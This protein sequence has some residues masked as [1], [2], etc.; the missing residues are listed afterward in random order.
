[1]ISGVLLITLLLANMLAPSALA[2]YDDDAQA[3][4]T[5]ME[6][7]DA[8]YMFIPETLEITEETFANNISI[9]D[10]VVPL[11]SGSFL[12]RI[13]SALNKILGGGSSQTTPAPT[14]APTPAP[15]AAPT[16][17]PTAAPT[18]APTAAPTPVPTAAATPVPTATA[19]PTPASPTPTLAPTP[20][21]TVAP[22]PEPDT[23]AANVAELR[24]RSDVVVGDII[25][26][27]GY[28]E[29]EDGGG[30]D[31]EIVAQTRDADNG[32]TIIQL[33]AGFTAK[34]IIANEMNVLQF[35]AVNDG[36]TDSQYAIQAAFTSGASVLNFPKD[37]HL[38]VRGDLFPGSNQTILGNNCT[39]YTDNDYVGTREFFITIRDAQ[40][41]VI[42]GL[43]I[44]S[45]QTMDLVHRKHIALARASNITIANCV[46]TGPEAVYKEDGS[47]AIFAFTNI[48]LYTAWNNVEIY[49]CTLKLSHDGT[50][51][52]TI[53]ARDLLGGVSS[54]LKFH[55][56][57]IEKVCHDELIAVGGT[58]ATVSNVQIYEN[59]MIA[60]DGKLTSSDVAISLGTQGTVFVD[61]VR[62]EN[63]ILDVEVGSMLFYLNPLGNNMSIT[64]NTFNLSKGRGYETS[65]SA[66]YA[67]S[68][69]M[70]ANPK[71]IE[72][73]NNII[74]I[75]N[76]GSPNGTINSVLRAN[77][78]ASGNTINID[79]D[80]SSIFT[81]CSSLRNNII[82]ITGNLGVL[83]L[84]AP[85]V[86]NNT[87][88]I[89][90]SL[91]AAF[92]FSNY[93]L[94][95]DGATFDNNVISAGA[96]CNPRSYL[97]QGATLTL[98]QND[99]VFSNNTVDIPPST[100]GT[101]YRCSIA[102]LDSGTVQ[103]LTAAPSKLE[104]AIS[105]PDQGSILFT[106]D[107]SFSKTLSAV[108][109][110]G[111]VN[112]VTLESETTNIDDDDTP[113]G[114]IP[115][116]FTETGVALLLAAIIIIIALIVGLLIFRRKKNSVSNTK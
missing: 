6:L 73:H 1:M 102:V 45:L 114:A 62:F 47:A 50:A 33:P 68:Q 46:L 113:G 107:N 100:A 20:T 98:G 24:G 25:S 59:T 90:G 108:Y 12:S 52:C 30:A 109:G 57:T 38:M 104:A 78:N 44:T 56:N 83:S 70:T 110:T 99:I 35:G 29:E 53:M 22:T 51:G 106:P 58:R 87:V 115:G 26:T 84:N 67:F 71:P 8:E 88:K 5:E 18:P 23:S 37:G 91:Q 21:P 16:P 10:N 3:I 93:T 63:N 66:C 116:P 49:G 28:F 75:N 97:L 77:A 42:D 86:N 103:R 9:G 40:N 105:N 82:N 61:D 72:F 48:D 15:T 112:I 39:L 89:S 27:R 7:Q 55:N 95:T 101:D 94:N 17:A 85:S 60:R 111:G 14:A 65:S 81:Y 92:K 36:S 19:T 41:I 54:G 74:N 11:S 76:T 64:G 69:W 31:Y 34:L 80:I 13:A 2:A 32:M 96:S 4:I 79:G 43:N